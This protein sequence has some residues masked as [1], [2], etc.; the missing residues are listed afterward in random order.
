MCAH[1]Q[2]ELIDCGFG[3]VHPLCTVV[4]CSC[5]AYADVLAHFHTLFRKFW[6]DC[7]FRLMQISGDQGNWASRLVAGLKHIQTPVVLMLCDDYYLEAPVHTSRV[8]HRLD[9][10]RAAQALNMRLIPNPKNGIPQGDGLM[11]YRKNTAYCVATQAGLW[12]RAFLIDRASRVASIWEFERFGSYS[13]TSEETRPLLA[14]Q[15]KEFPFVDAVHK[16]YWEKFGVRVCEENGLV[17]NFKTRSLPPLSIRLREGFKALIFALFPHN[18]IVRVQNALNM[19]MTE[20]K[21]R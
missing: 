12:D 18:W 19:G 3:A 11:E 14:T 6:P 2:D 5:T 7:P 10:M 9:Q 15:Q 4:V 1:G 8:L 21:V 16:G 20:K 17:I 13:F